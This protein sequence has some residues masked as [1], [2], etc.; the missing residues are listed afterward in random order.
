M[1]EHLSIDIFGVVHGTAD[2]S[3]AISALAVIAIAALVI[4]WLRPT[5]RADSARDPRP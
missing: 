2:G 1:S 5:Q 3:L 4:R